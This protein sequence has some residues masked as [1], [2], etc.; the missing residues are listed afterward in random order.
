MIQ[1]RENKKLAYDSLIVSKPQMLAVLGSDLAVK[2]LEEI[3]KLPCCAMDVARKLKVHEQ[4]V[5]YHVRNLEKNGFI[6]PVST[7]KRFG[8]TAK[9]YT[10]VS[11]VIAT[12]IFEGGFEVKNEE[13]FIHPETMR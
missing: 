4:K 10:I 12:K 1:Q 7:E 9:I 8:M 3:A 5:Y 6:Y 13:N 11:P 2:I